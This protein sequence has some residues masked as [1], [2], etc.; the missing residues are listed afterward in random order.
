MSYDGRVFQWIQNIYLVCNE[1]WAPGR[2]KNGEG[3]LTRCLQWCSTER[4]LTKT[5]MHV[6]N[7]EHNRLKLLL[8]QNSHHIFAPDLFYHHSCLRYSQ[9][10][11]NSSKADC[12]VYKQKKDNL[13]AIFY[14]KIRQN[15]IEE[16]G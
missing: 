4:F 16:R 2:N 11:Q 13:L 5:E 14:S 7:K 3:G 12:K 6:S 1:Q 8:S 10:R 9:S 15:K